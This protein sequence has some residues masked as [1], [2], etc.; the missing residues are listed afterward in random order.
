M[1]QFQGREYALSRADVE[2]RMRGLRPDRIT[3]YFVDVNG[4]AYPVKQVAR[5]CTGVHAQHTRESQQLLRAL[6]FTIHRAC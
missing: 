3:R 5:A 4:H 1:V 2:T 6:G